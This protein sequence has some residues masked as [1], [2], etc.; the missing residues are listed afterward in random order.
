[1]AKKGRMI[2][3]PPVLIEEASDIQREQ[4]I[5][6]RAEAVKKLVGYA[7][8]GRELERIMKLDFRWRPVQVPTDIDED[9]QKRIKGLFSRGIL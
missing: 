8:T 2:Y 5:P 4:N 6:L 7:K 3:V 1:M 9:K